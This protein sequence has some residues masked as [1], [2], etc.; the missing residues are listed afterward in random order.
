VVAFVEARLV[1]D[2][3]DDPA[4]LVDFRSDRRAMLFDMG[5]LH[6]IP[7]RKLLRVSHVFVSHTHLDHVIGFDHLLR[8]R[9]GR[10]N[11][12]SLIGP[13]GLVDRIGGRLAGYSWNLLKQSATDFV[14][15]VEE[16]DGRFLT[17]AA[18]FH[19]RE[20]F[21]QQTVA[22]SSLPPGVVLDEERFT[23]RC[24]LLDH[25]IPSLAFAFREKPRLNVWKDRL[26]GMGLVVG[27]WLT[28]AR[29]AIS[30]GDPDDAL[31]P[32]RNGD[33]TTTQ[34]PLGVLKI[35]AFRPGPGVSFAYVVDVAYHQ[36]NA[37]RIIDLA[38]GIGTLFIEAMFADE[39][40]AIAAARR[41][42]TAG[43]AGLLACQA[44]VHQVVPF[45]HSPRYRGQEERLRWQL[46]AAFGGCS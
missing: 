14:I 43:Q 6:A 27:P 1:N 10:P 4:L 9:L 40:G 18:A 19:S 44:Q 31:I 34:V 36:M 13:P 29:R 30:R 33:G 38:H 15:V 2:P 16:F 21:A 26:D 28:Y 12:L 3:F 35:E 23:V 46:L 24:A 11:A 42:L 20:A 17:R 25:G 37:A 32:A 45:H 7:A 5:E 41:H 22:P 39:D 8:F